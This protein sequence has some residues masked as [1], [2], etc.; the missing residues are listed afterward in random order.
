MHSLLP[1]TKRGAA[2]A[3]VLTLL[4][5]LLL[6]LTL[7]VTLAGYFFK[8]QETAEPCPVGYYSRGFSYQQACQPCPPRFTTNGTGAALVTECSKCFY[9][10]A[11]TQALTSLIQRLPDPARPSGSNLQQSFR[12]DNYALSGPGLDIFIFKE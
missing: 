12:L 1:C 8:T 11:K 9:P 2:S 7:S 5:L 3:V 6:L 4:L 10:M